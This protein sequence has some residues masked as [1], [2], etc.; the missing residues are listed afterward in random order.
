MSVCSVRALTAPQK[1]RSEYMNIKSVA[2][3]TETED[4]RS[5]SVGRVHTCP[6]TC[7]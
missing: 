6:N 4:L 1:R 7:A 5:L 2:G 3:D